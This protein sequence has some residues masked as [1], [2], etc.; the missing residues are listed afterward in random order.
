LGTFKG[1]LYLGVGRRVEVGEGYPL[2]ATWP[3]ELTIESNLK[4]QC[5]DEMDIFVE[6]LNILISTFCVLD[7][8]FQDLS[9]AF[10]YPVVQLLTFI[11]FFEFNY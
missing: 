9:I 8:G 6:G 5:H 10:H 4:G 3:W 7:D 1:W 2:L 11:C